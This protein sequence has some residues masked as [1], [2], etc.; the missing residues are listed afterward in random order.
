MAPMYPAGVKPSHR[1]RYLQ[2][3]RTARVFR[4]V[5][6][7]SR[8]GPR[9]PRYNQQSNELGP[10][11]PRV[12]VNPHEI[13]SGVP[14]ALA[15]VDEAVN[16]AADASAS[17]KRAEKKERIKNEI[18]QLDRELLKRLMKQKRRI[19]GHAHAGAQTRPISSARRARQGG[20]QLT[21][22]SIRHQN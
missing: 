21:R 15:S 22:T 9:D 6:V 17:H 5:D 8:E 2:A 13:R 16:K 11:R 20:D 4:A 12:V 19:L 7:A 18:L 3:D 1:I 10:P 14:I